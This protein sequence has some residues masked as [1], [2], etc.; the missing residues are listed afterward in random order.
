MTFV[1][2]LAGL[3]DFIQAVG[4]AEC[5]VL[6]ATAEAPAQEDQEHEAERKMRG[7]RFRILTILKEERE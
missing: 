5:E 6:E 2:G 4:E 1:P 3:A 7:A